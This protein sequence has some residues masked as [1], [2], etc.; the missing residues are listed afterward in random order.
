MPTCNGIRSR[1]KAVRHFGVE[2]LRYAYNQKRCQICE[3]FMNVEGLY[4]PCCHNRLRL[5]TRLGK[6]KIIM[7]AQRKA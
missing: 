3:I 4:C 2:G 7:Q 5:K 1:Y 6:A